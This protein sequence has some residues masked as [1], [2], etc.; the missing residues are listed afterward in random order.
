[1]RTD[2][3]P[4]FLIRGRDTGDGPSPAGLGCSAVCF[5]LVPWLARLQRAGWAAG[6]LLQSVEGEPVSWPGILE[7]TTGVVCHMCDARPF[8]SVP[9]NGSGMGHKQ[10]PW[11]TA[12]LFKQ[13]RPYLRHAFWLGARTSAQRDVLSFQSAIKLHVVLYG[14]R[15]SWESHGEQCRQGAL[16]VLVGQWPAAAGCAARRSVSLQGIGDRFVYEVE[17]IWV[18]FG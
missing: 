7:N 17:S 11:A 10:V 2:R 15:R 4:C 9:L 14:G 8:L 13:V 1:M 5:I 3:D 12:G 16:E 18:F 6:I